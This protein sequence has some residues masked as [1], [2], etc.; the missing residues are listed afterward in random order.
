MSL[1]RRS[2]FTPDFRFGVAT[3]AYQIEGAGFGGAGRSHWDIF[4]RT[5]RADAAGVDGVAACAHELHF[6]A[7]LD[8]VARAGFDTYRFSMSWARLLPEGKGAPNRAGLAFYD[9]LLDE[10]G[11]RG[12]APMLTL[13]HWDLPQALAEPRRGRDGATHPQGWQARDTALRFGDY[14][15]LVARRFGDRLAA[16][17][18]VSAPD[19]VAWRGHFTGEH[20]P[21]L[22][23][24]RATARAMHHILLGHGQAVAACRAAGVAQIGAACLIAPICVEDEASANYDALHNRFYIEAMLKGRY[25]VR[26]LTGLERF[27]PEGWGDDLAQIAAPLDWFGLNYAPSAPLSPAQ[28]PDPA[29]LDK[30]QTLL[31]QRPLWPEY[32]EIPADQTAA[33]SIESAA[34]A[35]VPLLAQIKADYTGDLPL[36]ITE[37][38]IG[39]PE[40][41]DQSPDPTGDPARIAHLDAHLR[42]VQAAL[43]AGIPLKGYIAWSLLDTYDWALGSQARFGLVQVDRSTQ[44]RRPKH[45]WHALARALNA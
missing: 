44:E 37:C 40:A 8:L 2:E 45:S 5:T 6:A 30:G 26:A 42:A 21:G 33:Y 25:P 19:C 3:S 36:W 23:D 15:D 41:P 16:V 38:G 17:I 13:Y 4:A 32:R 43:A 31:A 18:P 24:I 39:L 27:L 20:A 7:D 11:A 14:A 22:R 34:A 9:R 10:M 1:P 29:T 35:L 12:L 28:S